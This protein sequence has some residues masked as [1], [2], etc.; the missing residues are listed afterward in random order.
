MFV[1]LD[2]VIILSDYCDLLFGENYGVVMEEFC[3]LVCVV[4]VLDVDNK[5]VYKEIVSEG[6][7]FLDFDVVLV[8]Y[9]N[10]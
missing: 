6:I 9:K 10:I 5:V 4:F 2:N 1:G 8:V 3:L 7:D